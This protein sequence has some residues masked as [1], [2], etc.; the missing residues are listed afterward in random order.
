MIPRLLKALTVD[1][2]ADLL[3]HCHLALE[4][5]LITVKTVKTLRLSWPDTSV[6]EMRWSK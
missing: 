3:L 5:S 1:S 2:R 6:R 4:A